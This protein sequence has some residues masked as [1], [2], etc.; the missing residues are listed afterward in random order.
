MGSLQNNRGE[1]IAFIQASIQECFRTGREVVYEKLISETCL[2][3]NCMRRTAVEYISIIMSS[4]NLVKSNG[5]ICPKGK[6][7]QQEVSA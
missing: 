1:R 5:L 6:E 4:L 7:K 3:Y 2:K